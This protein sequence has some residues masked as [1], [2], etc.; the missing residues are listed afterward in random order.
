[1][2]MRMVADINRVLEIAARLPVFPCSPDKSPRVKRGFHDA[3]QDEAT[4]RKWWGQWPDSLVGVPTGQ[5]T[6]LV[7]IDYDP[8]NANNATHSWLAEHTDLLCSTRVHKTAR[9]GMHYVFR[10]NERY[11]T[12]TDL[13]LGGSPRR[14]IDLR[15]NG[16]YVIWWPAHIS[17]A[18]A[19]PVAALPANLI[20]E[21]RFDAERDLAPLPKA[22]PADWKR[23]R[24]K[25]GEALEFLTPNGYQNWI[26]AGMAIHSASGGS[27]DGFAMWHAWSETG[28]SYDGIEDCRYHWQ[29]FGRYKGRGIG[30]GSL[31]AAAKA[32]GFVLSPPEPHTEPEQAEPTQPIVF[33]HIA[34]I[35]AEKREPEW[36]IDDVIEEN[37]LAVLAGKRGSYKSFVALDWSMRIAVDD[38][39][40]IVLSGEGAGLDRRVDAWMR[41]HGGGLDPREL[42]VYALE[43]PVN[44]NAQ[45]DLEAVSDAVQAMQRPP[46]MIVVDT[47]SKF[48]AGLDEN[49]NGEVGQ[50]LA[51][52]SER[53]RQRFK[54]TVLLVAH[55]GHADN[56]R[57]R[58]ASVLMANPDA[59]YLITRASPQTPYITVSRER[60]KDSPALDPLSYES[61]VI[62][63]GRR[64]KRGRTVTSL[65]LVKTDYVEDLTTKKLGANQQ[66]AMTALK[67]FCRNESDSE[68]H[69]TAI[70]LQDLLKAQGVPRQRR[71]EV[72]A[73]LTGAGVIGPAVG[74]H[75]VR[76]DAF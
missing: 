8:D 48:S 57:P 69:I 21:R 40:V 51:R 32:E 14:G 55:T 49:D 28:D 71:P 52:L 4:I 35:L 17:Q 30:L 67:E 47:F 42:P 56:G 50:Y 44:L 27:D 62:D 10:S 73:W 75:K 33:R 43:R 15:A 64:D 68:P 34:D 37:V 70:D 6:G 3:T 53:L 46:A 29:S 36:L 60:F 31:F 22:S 59:E 61:K 26:K 1:M 7:V 20:D 19:A 13:V 5:R 18:D 12:G 66:K 72:V 76:R 45:A 38:K 58:G 25:A 74:G 39:P 16:G 65:A 54:A 11:Q 63:L 9:G 41:T 2:S 24:A 23:D